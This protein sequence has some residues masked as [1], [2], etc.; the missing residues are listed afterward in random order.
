MPPWFLVAYSAEGCSLCTENLNS[1][2][3]ICGFLTF[4]AKVPLAFIDTDP[5]S[6]LHRGH[7]QL[8]PTEVTNSHFCRSSPR[9]EDAAFPLHIQEGTTVVLPH[10][11][12]CHPPKPI[13]TKN[14]GAIPV[15]CMLKI[16]T[17]ARQLTLQT[18]QHC[19]SDTS[20]NATVSTTVSQIPHQ[21]R[22][23]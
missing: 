5:S 8:S 9:E 23:P 3:R 14:P 17:R 2:R 20:A 15:L 1:L 4:T 16:K 21:E 7:L 18:L 19:I 6:L 10:D 22:H 13:L 11:Q 12:C